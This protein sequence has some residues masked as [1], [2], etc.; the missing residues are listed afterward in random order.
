MEPYQKRWFNIMYAILV[1]YIAVFLT[2]ALVPSDALKRKQAQFL[3]YVGWSVV[4]MG[5]LLV[6][7]FLFA[8]DPTPERFAL[9]TTVMGFVLAEPVLVPVSKLLFP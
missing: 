7:R 6:I 3:F 5:F 1:V 9:V 4:A 8:R 2:L